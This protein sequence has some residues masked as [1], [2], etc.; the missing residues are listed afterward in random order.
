M[1][2]FD[3]MTRGELEHRIEALEKKVASME[4]EVAWLGDLENAGVDNW[5]GYD[6]A[7]QLRRER[8]AEEGGK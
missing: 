4:E 5:Q 2:K 7:I 6:F 3:G 8:L 1:S